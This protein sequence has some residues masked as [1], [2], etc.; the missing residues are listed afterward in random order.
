[1]HQSRS[2]TR[3]IAATLVAA[4]AVAADAIAPAAAATGC[5][6]PAFQ[7]AEV[8][9]VAQRTNAIGAAYVQNYR[10]AAAA[11][12]IGWRTTI[13]ARVPCSPQLRNV[14][15]HLLRNLGDL[16]RSYTATAAGDTIDGLSWLALASTEAA[17]ANAGLI[18]F[19]REMRPPG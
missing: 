4:G 7:K 16:W 9:A 8:A 11:S 10:L 15:T 5:S 19:N 17:R 14:R 18:I 3:S 6:D 2:K 12:F 13:S 1:M